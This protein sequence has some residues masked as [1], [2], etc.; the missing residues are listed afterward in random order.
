[1]QEEILKQVSSSI[2]PESKVFLYNVRE[3][4]SCMKAFNELQTLVGSIVE[5][6][7]IAFKDMKDDGLPQDKLIDLTQILSII[8][9]KISKT[10]DSKRNV[11]GKIAEIQSIDSKVEDLIRNKNLL[12]KSKWMAFADQ[13][14]NFQENKLFDTDYLDKTRVGRNKQKGS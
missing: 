4:L 10:L 11:A 7:L 5:K 6:K 2:T 13:L 9:D 1:M 8:E 12:Q 14:L 3:K